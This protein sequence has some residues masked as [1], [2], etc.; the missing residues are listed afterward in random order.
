MQDLRCTDCGQSF[1]SPADLQDHSDR[2]HGAAK[3]G[4]QPIVGYP[5]SEP[6][7]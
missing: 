4:G 2:I 5:P 1:K 6:R 3:K 7:R